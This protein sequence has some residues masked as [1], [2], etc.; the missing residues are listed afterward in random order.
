M[1]YANKNKRSNFW[2]MTSGLTGICSE[3]VLY[4]SSNKSASL[5]TT[6]ISPKNSLQ[7]S[8]LQCNELSEDLN[9]TI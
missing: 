3:R 5:M 9:I 7:V 2:Q 6:T 4:F 1:V 8:A